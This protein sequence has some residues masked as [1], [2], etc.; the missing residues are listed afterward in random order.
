[1][2]Q[3]LLKRLQEPW[4]A[5]AG[6]IAETPAD[7]MIPT[8]SFCV[9][10]RYTTSGDR[11]FQTTTVEHNRKLQPNPDMLWVPVTSRC[12]KGPRTRRVQLSVNVFG[13]LISP[14]TSYTRAAP[15][16]D[17]LHTPLTA[18]MTLASCPIGYQL[19]LWSRSS[20]SWLLPRSI[21]WLS[22]SCNSDRSSLKS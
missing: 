16:K 13:V 17:S 21:A 15:P 10:M 12:K 4:H 19:G 6:Q 3:L 7:N 2:H 20:I 9:A 22:R 14:W 8:F 11:K 1:M 5:S 18:C